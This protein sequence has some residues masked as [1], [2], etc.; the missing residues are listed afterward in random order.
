MASGRSDSRTGQGRGAG[1]AGLERKRVRALARGASG[2]AGRW[3]GPPDTRTGSSLT[4]EQL[5]IVPPSC[6]AT[7][8]P[9]SACPAV[10]ATALPAV[11]VGVRRRVRL[12]PRPSSS[13]DFAKAGAGDGRR[14][15]ACRPL[16]GQRALGQPAVCRCHL[17]PRRLT[18]GLHRLNPA[19]EAARIWWPR[20]RA[21]GAW[22][23]VWGG[24]PSQ[25][26]WGPWRRLPP[27]L[28]PLLL[29]QPLPCDPVR[30]QQSHLML[31]Q[32][33]WAVMSATWLGQ[34]SPVPGPSSGAGCLVPRRHVWADSP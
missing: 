14:G 24:H 2:E 29:S 5:L 1:T 31:G 10:G 6:D 17:R 18:L 28:R 23:G 30:G 21:G 7:A 11:G 4:A 19:P 12:G 20:G 33:L 22:R 9:P 34:R 3:E 16:H 15:G 13:S 25:L 32:G 27:A 26:G 8:R